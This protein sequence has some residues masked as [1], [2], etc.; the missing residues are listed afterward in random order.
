M[1]IYK[2][3]Y[4]CLIRMFLLLLLCFASIW[5]WPSLLCTRMVSDWEEV[6]SFVLGGRMLL[7]Q[8]C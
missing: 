8:C 2:Y 3:T 6:L 7:K 5:N 4:T 1:H